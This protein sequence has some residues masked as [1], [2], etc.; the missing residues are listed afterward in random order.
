MPGLPS[1]ESVAQALSRLLRREVS[2]VLAAR[3]GRRFDWG[4]PRS[5]PVAFEVPAGDDPLL[6]CVVRAFLV[7]V[8]HGAVDEAAVRSA[9]E[10]RLASG[11]DTA[12]SRSELSP[13]DQRLRESIVDPPA[14][15]LPEGARVAVFV[16]ASDPRDL[17]SLGSS[18]ATVRPCWG[19]V[20]QEVCTV[21]LHIDEK[22]N[23]PLLVSNRDLP[24]P[25]RETIRGSVTLHDCFEF[26]AQRE[27][28]D[29]NNPWICEQCNETVFPD[30]KVDI[31]SVPEVFIVHLKRFSGGYG[32]QLSKV[33]DFVDYP[34]EIDMAKYVVGP[35]KDT[36]LKYRLYAVSNHYGSLGGGHYT[37]N[38]IV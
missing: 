34:Y 33:N 13:A 23:F 36:E 35:Q 6:R 4:A 30:K 11:W 38:A 7:A 5:S 17:S 18:V 10:E 32:Y 21:V 29:E 2:V 15:Q 31:W 9:V 16:T 8:P 19:R 12:I 28:L 22:F 26:Y 14:A 24:D 1:N 25:Q 20:C 37:A 27:T 3:R